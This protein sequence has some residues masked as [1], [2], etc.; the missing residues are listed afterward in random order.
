MKVMGADGSWSPISLATAL[1]STKTYTHNRRSKA[2]LDMVNQ[3]E[4]TLQV[5]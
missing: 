1:M 4:K 2:G 5:M 3:L